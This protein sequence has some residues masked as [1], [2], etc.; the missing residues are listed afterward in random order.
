MAENKEGV[1]TK[2]TGK[3]TWTAERDELPAKLTRPRLTKAYRRTRLVELLGQA[4]D[5]PAVWIGAQ[6]GAGKTTLAASWVDAGERTSL[7][8]Q[9]DAGDADLASFFHHLGLA[10]KHLAPRHK[11]PLPHLTPEYLPGIEIFAR[12]FF[13]ELFRRMPKDSV[14]VL[15]NIQDSGSDGPLDDILRIAVESIPPHVKML[16]VSRFAPPQTFARLRANGQLAVLEPSSIR[17]T[18]EEAKGIAALRGQTEDLDATALYERTD[19]WVAGLVLML[20]GAD[21]R[22]EAKVSNAA[23]RPDMQTLFN[24]FASEVVRGLDEPRRQM[25]IKSAL[26]AKMRVS[27]VE[28][29]CGDPGVGNML[30]ELQQQNYFTYRLSPTMPVYEYHPLFREFL[31]ARLKESVAPEVLAALRTRAAEYA[32]ATGSADEAIAL[33]HAAKA[34]DAIIR[35]VC[36]I[37]P[38]LLEQ[39]RG[40]TLAGWIESL[41]AEQRG[42]NPWLHFWFGQCRLPFAPTD[43]RLQFERALSLFEQQG[44]RAGALLAWTG[45]VDTALHEGQGL[46]ALDGWIEA[47]VRIAGAEPLPAALHDRIVAQMFN[48]LMLRQPSHP[49]IG[50][51][52]ERSFVILESGG[53]PGLRLIAGVNLCIYFTWMG[54]PRRARQSLDWLTSLVR[55]VPVPPLMTQLVSA[56]AAMYAWLAEADAPKSLAIV[57]EALASGERTGVYVWQHHLLCEGAAA[58]LTA[59]DG[60]TAQRL[61]RRF[62]EG[63]AQA[64]LVDVAYYHFLCNWD[65]LGRGDLGAAEWH[66][67]AAAPL[68]ERIGLTFGNTLHHLM[69]ARTSIARGRFEEARPAF[70][71]L[72]RLAAA[73]GSKLV[74]YMV[75]TDE[76][77][78]ALR[79]GDETALRHWL[80]RAFGLGR[81]QGLVTFHGWEAAPMARLCAHALEAGI[82]TEYVQALIRRRALVPPPAPEPSEAWPWPL[83][84]HAL[85][86]FELISNGEPMIF[87]GKIQQKPL[88]LLKA[89]I[90][91]GGKDVAEEQFADILWPE[92]DGDLAHKSF[93]MTVQR[94]RRLIGNPKI[95]QLQERRLSFDPSLCWIDVWEL[96]YLLEKVETDWKS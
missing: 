12:R 53:D 93:E 22:H 24:Y 9:V 67:N 39:G 1:E 64:R 68:R 6:P 75:C 82:A 63:L 84:I 3:R 60:A 46:S 48:A 41:P 26:L 50:T 66:A 33:W 96:G 71:E 65:A 42:G 5:A 15:D 56:A 73:T 34:W 8:Y 44:E 74:E 89:L 36:R 92:A 29:L 23:N 19:G 80:T 17:L 14:L 95:I 30:A 32:A 13:E 77:L 81:E 40:Q 76:A 88:A 27:D 20:H 62:S 94:L 55:G 31:L 58:A 7:W 87:S 28:S 59:G 52:A 43:A 2:K 61:L 45:L 49:D 47:F 54:E 38:S 79:Q 21:E 85:G 78:L 57:E 25:L 91:L 10:A 51:W 72:H 86:K 90:A 11:N 70:D 37:A 69:E 35:Y 4:F 83:K 16:C 18:L